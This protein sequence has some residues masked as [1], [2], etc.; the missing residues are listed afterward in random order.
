MTIHIIG[1]GLAGLST[2]VRLSRIGRRVA[3][4]ESAGQA[5]GRCRS[6]HDAILDRLIDNGN[7]LLLSGNNDTYEYLLMLGVVDH[8]VGPPKAA[9]P[10]LDLETDERWCLEPGAGRIPWWIF[11]RHRRVPG[12]GV[13]SYLR[14]IRLAFAGPDLTVARCLGEGSRLYR[15]FWEPL[16]VAAL[17]ASGEEGAAQLLWPV[18][19]ETFGRGEAACRP[20]MARDGL[21]P[22]F[23]DPAVSFLRKCDIEVEFGHRCKAIDEDGERITALDLGSLHLDLGPEDVVVLAVPPA[24]ASS[25]IKKI[26]VPVGN[27]SIL[28]LHFKLEEAVGDLQVIGLVGGLSQ[29]VF[30]RGDVASVTVSAAD[31]WMDA[32]SEDLAKRAWPEVCRALG[33]PETPLPLHRVVKEKRATFAQTPDNLA[34]R[35]GTRTAWRNLVL[36]GDW[37]D[38]GLP[39]TIEGAIRSGRHAAEAVQKYVSHS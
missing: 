4:W 3:V 32:D 34:R 38:T 9:F 17:N 7:H 25:L 13:W 20:R 2:A 37:T 22:A 6:Y 24:Q 12:T 19:K 8:L 21:G 10:F 5:G 18:L 23:I 26:N 39:A 15:R 31:A 30:A 16:A 36:A 33:R 28:N 35:P 29:W 14:G 11:N 1:A 27:R